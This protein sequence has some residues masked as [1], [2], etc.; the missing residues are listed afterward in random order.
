MERSIN[1]HKGLLDALVSCLSADG[2]LEFDRAIS[3]TN[4]KRREIS[5][6]CKPKN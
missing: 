6:N 5:K 1:L 2:K 3:Q 4:D